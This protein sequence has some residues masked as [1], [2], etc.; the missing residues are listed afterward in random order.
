MQTVLNEVSD[1]TD[2]ILTAIAGITPVD[3]TPVLTALSTIQS[4]V[5]VPIPSLSGTF[6]IALS[7]AFTEDWFGVL[8]EIELTSGPSS[9]HLSF[10]PF[11]AL[12]ALAVDVVTIPAGEGSY[13]SGTDFREPDLWR[14]AVVRGGRTLYA[15]VGKR[16][17][18]LIPPFWTGPFFLWPETWDLEFDVQPGAEIRVYQYVLP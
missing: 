7:Q 5:T 2:E 14:M 16:E 1:D 10:T 6:P 13:P 3:L 8:S 4:S 15:T 11:L 9:G 17:L 12:F 18:T